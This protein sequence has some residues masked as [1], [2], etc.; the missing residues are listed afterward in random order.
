MILP[1]WKGN[2]QTMNARTTT[3]AKQDTG[4]RISK[5]IKNKISPTP[6]QEIICCNK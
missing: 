5:S 4:A 1:T 2:Q 3:T 6:F